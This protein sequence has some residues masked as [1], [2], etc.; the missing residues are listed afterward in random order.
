MTRRYT[1]L[2][3]LIGAVT[4]GGC[5]VTDRT[6]DDAQLAPPPAQPTGQPGDM[7]DPQGE[8]SIEVD[9]SARELYVYR[10]GQRVETHQVAIGSSEWP[11]RTGEWTIEEVVFNPRW[12]P[13]EEEWAEDEDEV[14]PGD[15]ENPLG[16]AQLVY[17]RP[18]SIHGT[19]APESIGQAVSHGSIRV[20]NEVA[21]ELARKVMQ[22]GGA[23]NGDDQIRQ[24][25]QNPTQS[26]TVNLTR[27]V[28]IRVVERSTR[29][30]TQPAGQ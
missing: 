16:K 20:R 11:T 17:D 4:A 10:G 3:A 8:M 21:V 12:V 5:Q 1:V 19:N 6:D 24:A 27:P 30:Q 14:E 18:R 15:P 22:A 28:P 7:Q 23:T 26:Y 29:S 13:P 9:L 25:E 2:V